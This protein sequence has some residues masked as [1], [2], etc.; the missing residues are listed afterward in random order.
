MVRDSLAYSA[1]SSAERDRFWADFQNWPIPRQ[2]DWAH[3]FVNMVLG[4]DF[5]NWF[6]NHPPSKTLAEI[7]DLL[8]RLNKGF[9][10]PTGW[11]P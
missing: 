9:Q 11:Q 1:L 2:V 10:I 3:M 5:N 4:F 8:A 6:P 7:N